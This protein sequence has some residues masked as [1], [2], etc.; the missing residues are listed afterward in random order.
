MKL[1]KVDAAGSSE[2]SVPFCRTIRSHIQE[3]IITIV[4]LF[5]QLFIYVISYFEI[6]SLFPCSSCCVYTYFV[7]EGIKIREKIEEIR[8]YKT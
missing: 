3:V 1:L 2:T 4:Y 8:V 6:L 7:F 5:T